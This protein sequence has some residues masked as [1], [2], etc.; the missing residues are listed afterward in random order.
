MTDLHGGP[1]F[2]RPVLEWMEANQLPHS[3]IPDDAELDIDPVAAT[4]TVEVMAVDDDNRPMLH[5]DLVLTRLDTF[6]LLVAPDEGLLAAYQ[7]STARLRWQRDAAEAIRRE[8]VETI[9]AHL[10]R[11]AAA[12]D[13]AVAARA[14]DAGDDAGVAVSLAVARSHA[15]GR[16]AA[17]DDVWQAMGWRPSSRPHLVGV[18]P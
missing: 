17:V 11:V 8:T 6:P 16:L 10:Q 3:R 18:R 14:A 12:A 15:A 13:R 9:V 4:I 7:H 2:R 1:A 5:A